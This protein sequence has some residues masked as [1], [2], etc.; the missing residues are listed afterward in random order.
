MITMTVT[1]AKSK[2]LG[3]L[4]K[5]HDVGEIFSVTHNGT[6]YAVIMGQEDYEGLLETIDIL[7]DKVFTRD[8][9]SRVRKADKKNTLS[10]EKVA[11]RPQQR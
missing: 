8:L 1:A 9:I 7:Q 5:S 4:R 6:P 2:F 11:G 3:L 10:F